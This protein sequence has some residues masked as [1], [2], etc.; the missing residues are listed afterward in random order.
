MFTI[1]VKVPLSSK[2]QKL[3]HVRLGASDLEVVQTLNP[4]KDAACIFT[5]RENN[6][7]GIFILKNAQV[8]DFLSTSSAP[9]LYDSSRENFE[10]SFIT[11]PA[12]HCHSDL[13]KQSKLISELCTELLKVNKA[14]PIELEDILK[15]SIPN[16]FA[17]FAPESNYIWNNHVEALTCLG[18]KASD[19]VSQSVIDSFLMSL[20]QNYSF[21]TFSSF[22]SSPL[23]T[24]NPEVQKAY[25]ETFEKYG[26]TIGL[27]KAQLETFLSSNYSFDTCSD[28]IAE[29][30]GIYKEKAS[31]N[32]R[33]SLILF[34]KVTPLGSAMLTIEVSPFSVMLSLYNGTGAY[35][36]S[37]PTVTSQFIEFHNTVIQ[38]YSG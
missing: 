37:K 5:D 17:S 19:Y 34:M 12:D 8:S 33:D 14:I 23:I 38:K 13:A 24:V 3:T 28:F 7:Y 31:N 2:S 4:R 29:R 18:K 27:I 22:A 30:F 16:L 26:Q 10:Y 6:L 36:T 35:P 15:V 11:I 21:S 25:E 1:L 20:I 9:S 32:R